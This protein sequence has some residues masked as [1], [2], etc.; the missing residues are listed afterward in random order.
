MRVALSSLYLLTLSCILA[1]RRQ[2]P[3]RYLADCKD[4]VW[5]KAMKRLAYAVFAL[6]FVLIVI[7]IQS[8][9][10]QVQGQWASSGTM[11]SAR[12]LNAQ[13]LLSN[14]KVL[15]IGGG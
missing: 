15:S 4:R 13:A 11:Q 12:E 6:T 5:R 14:G 10:A 2:R 1:S 3:V 7:G 8:L 9:F